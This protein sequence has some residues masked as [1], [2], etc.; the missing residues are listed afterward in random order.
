MTMSAR[1]FEREV[2]NVLV[3]GLVF[4]L[5]LA[6]SSL[7]VLRNVAAWGEREALE[8][9][10]AEAE[11]IRERLRVTGD[12]VRA[13]SGDAA[14]ASILRAAG[15]RAA[16]VYDRGIRVAAALFLPDATLAPASLVPAARPPGGEPLV[17]SQPSEMPGI[18]VAVSLPGGDR[19]LWLLFDGSA[20]S[21]AR[22]DVR[23][24]SVV[25]PASAC[26]LV[27][28]VIPFLRRLVEPIEALT[29]TA[30]GASAVVTAPPAA[31]A[32]GRDEAERAIATFARTIEELK[33]RTD[34][35]ETLR[36]REKERADA[37]AVTAQ[38]LVRSHPGGLV[39]LDAE[40]RLSEAN[41]P[42]LAALGLT[43][44]WVGALA[45]KQFGALPALRDAAVLAQAGTATLARE[46]PAGS[47]AAERRLAVTA[48]PVADAAGRALGTLLFLEDRTATSR[49]EKELSARRE[50]AA[51]GEMSAG[52]AHEFRNAT[53]TILG[54]TRLAA[55]GGD[56]EA[57]RRHL[58]AIQA[59]AEHV[60][61][62]TG[63]FLF[64]A[65][66]EHLEVAPVALGPL[67]EDIVEEQRTITPHVTLGTEGAFATACVDPALFR[68][69]LVNLLRN[70]CEAATSGGTEPRVVVRGEGVVEGAASV[71]VEDDGPGVAPEAAGRLFVPFFSTKE[72]GTGLGLALVAKIV[73]LHGGAVRAEVS[74]AL[75][76]ARFV[77]SFPLGPPGPAG[78]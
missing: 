76:G 47:G 32:R 24:L 41:A 65:R 2:R 78:R 40:G 75:G 66:P 60:A 62:V 15:V 21:E 28:L 18:T 46:F 13:L 27:F 8:R 29:E 57:R 1:P 53:A 58:A 64:F 23:I 43:S 9:R 51:L 12:P 17:R 16:A 74:D 49:L 25:V 44:G 56:E 10:S 68:R 20:L 6:G 61:R 63:D 59:E 5:F 39:V 4:L 50:L 37:L 22:R 55:Q 67:V 31:E 30:R 42:A 11:A 3:G 54:Y 45:V 69:A 48:V 33:K 34:E 73:A 14:V 71:A 52:I 77:L 7:V 35:L 26:V 36:R 19:V 70:A 38:T 72:S